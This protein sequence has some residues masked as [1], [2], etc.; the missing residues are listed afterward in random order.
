MRINMDE[1]IKLI[2]DYQT[3]PFESS[4]SVSEWP[5]FVQR[6]PDQEGHP[7]KYVTWLHR[8]PFKFKEELHR[9]SGLHNYNHNA[10]VHV[11]TL[12]CP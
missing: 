5:V 7:S 4:Q 12:T 3:L 11:R 2:H 8:F 10:N 9:P 6:L 1:L